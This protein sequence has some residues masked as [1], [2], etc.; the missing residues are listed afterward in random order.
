MSH[1]W[2]AFSVHGFF[3]LLFLIKFRF[4]TM[5]VVG[6]GFHFGRSEVGTDN[7][8]DWLEYDCYKWNQV[9]QGSF[10]TMIYGNRQ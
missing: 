1:F 6:G 10:A 3:S 8:F 9:V 5:F 4:I 2:S 7:R